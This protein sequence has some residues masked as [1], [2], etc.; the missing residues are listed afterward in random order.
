MIPL[1]TATLAELGRVDS[2]AP[3]FSGVQ[4]DSRRIAAGELFVA[5]G[6]G[7]EFLAEAWPWRN[8]E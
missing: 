8:A 1:E 6:R 5:I 7:E 3:E 2:R 4:V